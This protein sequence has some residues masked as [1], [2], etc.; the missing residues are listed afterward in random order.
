MAWLLA[1]GLPNGLRALAYSTERLMQNWAA[2]RLEAAWRIRFSLKK[3]W[4]SCRPR[5]SAP[6]MALSG[7]RTSVNETCAWSVGM[8]NVHRYSS[9]LKPGVL[10]G[11]R[12]PVMPWPLPGSPLVRAKTRSCEATWMPVFQVFSPLITQS[13]PSRTALVSMKVASLPWFGSVMPKAKRLLPGGEVVHPLLLLLRA[14]VVQHQQQPHVV[15]HDRVLVLQVAV[16]AEALA[17]QVLADDRHAQVGAVPAA[18][19]LRERV[20]V[21]AGR[22]GPP[23]GLRRAAPPTRG[24]AGRRGPSR[25]WRPP[26]G[27]RRTFR[28]RP[29]AR[30]GGSRAR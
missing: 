27:G 19:L 28:C 20:P 5:P 24:W 11:T 23:P 9:I 8:L 26:G 15:A 2:P 30:A 29:A 16:Q 17:G 1:S 13:S 10:T 7:T 3:C 25:S 4:T 22:V 14:A 21:V 12:K 6:K 18:V